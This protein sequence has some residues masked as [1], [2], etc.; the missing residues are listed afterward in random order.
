[1]N[2]KL[3]W[4]QPTGKTTRHSIS[5]QQKIMMILLKAFL[6]SI[7][8]MLLL[9]MAGALAFAKLPLPGNL[10]RPAACVISGAGTAVSGLLLARGFGRQR[11]LCGLGGGVFYSLCIAGA[12]ALKGNFALE[13]RGIALICMLLLAGMLGGA[14]T[15]VRPAGRRVR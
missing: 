12:S 8:V 11:L 10:V 13:Q 5:D 7:A 14:L 2:H 4:K 9:F 15:A 1:M 3:K 6:G